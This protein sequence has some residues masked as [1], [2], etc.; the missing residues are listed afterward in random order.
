MSRRAPRALALFSC[1]L[2]TLASCQGS[3]DLG[4]AASSATCEICVGESEM[5]RVTRLEYELAVRSVLGDSADSVRF[6]YL[7]AD[8]S[9]GPF[10]S[11]AFLDVLV[12][13]VG[14]DLS[15]SKT[16]AG[17][18]MAGGSVTF[19]LRVGNAGPDVGPGPIQVVDLL[20]IGL[21]FS[22]SSRANLV[23]VLTKPSTSMGTTT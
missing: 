20:P 12:I 18:V 1:S 16:H 23:G 21:S 22:R 19:T 5:T 7:P 8:G 6:D 14:A 4:P 2:L 15:L 10:P 9:A 3:F 11:N 13:P 17:L